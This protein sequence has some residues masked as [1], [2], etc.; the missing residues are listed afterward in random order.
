MTDVQPSPAS[1]VKSGGS[2]Y[3]NRG[4]DPENYHAN[5]GSCKVDKHGL[6]LVPQPSVFKDD[7]LNWPRWLKWTILVQVSFMAFLGPFNAGVANPSLVLLGEAFHKST[8]AISYTT[9]IAILMGGVASFIWAPLTNVYGRRPVTIL[10]QIIA[11]LGNIGSAQSTSYSAL[12]GTRAL[13]GIGMSGM[14]S[15]GTVCLNDMFFLHER[16]EKT[17]VYTIL[18]TNGGHIAFLGGGYI[19]QAAGWAWDF[20]LPAIITAASLSFAV[21]LFL[22][23]SSPETQ[24]SWRDGLINGPTGRCCS[25]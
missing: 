1:D 24:A 9:T 8:T 2:Q 11:I 4:S 6:P 14:M 13:N 3:E 23:R 22:K 20:W 18:V 25:T 5:L 12:L 15:V 19:A 17:G 16:G 10:S 21:F 7:P